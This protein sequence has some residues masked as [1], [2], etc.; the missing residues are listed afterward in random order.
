MER[1]AQETYNRAVTVNTGPGVVARKG[2]ILY[3]KLHS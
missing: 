3:S 2:K 1:L